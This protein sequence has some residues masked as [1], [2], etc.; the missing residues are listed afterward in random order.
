MAQ[1]KRLHLHEKPSRFEALMAAAVDAI[2]VIDSRGLIQ[3]FNPAAERLF[4]YDLTEV[5]GHNVSVLMPA[6]YAS[7]HDHYLSRY[8]ATGEARIIGIGREVV[9]QRK[10]GSVFPIDLSV[11][12]VMEGEV[13]YFVGILRDISDRKASEEALRQREEAL[14]QVVENAPVGILTCDRLSRI[15]SCNFTLN[16]MLGYR[17]TELANRYLAD[18]LHPHDLG[19]LR[20][21]T[22]RLFAG[23]DEIFYLDVRLRHAS[24]EEVPC[25]MV[26][27]AVHDA[28]GKPQQMIVQL[29]DLSEQLAA[30]QE[31]EVHRE[32]LTHVTRLSTL[33]EMAAGIAHE[34]N[35]PLT[36][37]A[38]YAQAARRLQE[39]GAKEDLDSALLKIA[40]Q[41][42]RAAAVIKRLRAFVKQQESE[43]ELMDANDLV[44]DVIQ[45]LH[46]DSGRRNVDI[47]PEY[48]PRLP[49]VLADNVQ[50]Q[51]VLLNLL[52]NAMD[53]T[54]VMEHNH[55]IR[56][57]TY[58]VDDE[59][60]A[61]EVVDQGCGVSE[62]QQINL[63]TPFF[64]TKASGMGMGLPICRSIIIAHGG[65]LNYH[66]NP[67]G[68]SI[69]RFTLPA[70]HES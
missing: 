7:E 10:D 2:I 47:I 40:Q 25:R 13:S 14:R 67:E 9:A 51:Q 37:I 12:E 49:R 29:E 55:G 11:G 46:L 66:P 57:R 56:I 54:S 39:K 68:G 32:R 70:I 63:F 30:R 61:F 22:D 8:N 19:A 27:G 60:V 52:L 18:I 31:A 4:G 1:P 36:A 3:E 34:I 15:N 21:H 64:T 45:F 38:T 59:T 24:G 41:A 17:E 65:Q 43:Q 23:D 20:T 48:S 69:F 44:A 42:E 28:L 50:I 53:A 35:Q 6:P 58:S 33:G 16:R 62:E 26:A 5:V